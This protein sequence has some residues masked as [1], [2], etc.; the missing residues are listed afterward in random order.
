MAAAPPDEA[1]V[2]NLHSPPAP[3]GVRCP[4]PAEIMARAVTFNAY[5]EVKPDAAVA[6]IR[7]AG[8]GEQMLLYDVEALSTSKRTLKRDFVRH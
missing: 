3:S 2:T 7:C 1:Y 8:L 4:L 6:A 5:G